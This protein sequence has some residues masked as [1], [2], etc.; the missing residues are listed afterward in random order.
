MPTTNYRKSGTDLDSLFEPIGGETKRA[1][2]SYRVN[3]TDISN[4][5]A[6][7]SSGSPYGTTS[8]RAGGT[9]IGSLFAAIGS[10][11]STGILYG[12]GRNQRAELAIVTTPYSWIVMGINNLSFLFDAP[13]AAI[14][15]DYKLFT[16]GSNI[17]GELGLN[18]VLNSS[19]PVQ[20]GFDTDWVAISAGKNFSAAI[21]SDGTLWVWGLNDFGQLGQGNLVDSLIPIQ[22]GTANDWWQISCGEAFMVGLKANRQLYAWGSNYR[23]QLGDASNM[24]KNIPTAIGTANDWEKI[25]AGG[26]HSIARKMNGTI[27]ATGYNQTGQLG[28]GGN[29]DDRNTYGQAGTYSLWNEIATGRFHSLSIRQNTDVRTWGANNTGQLGDGTLSASN[30]PRFIACPTT[31]SSTNFQKSIFEVYPNPVSNQLQ[32]NTNLP[33]F[34]FSIFSIDNKLIK[35]G[36]NDLMIDFSNFKAGIYLLE[37]Y[38]NEERIIKKIIKQ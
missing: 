2:V 5:Y 11:S 10:V 20:L 34:N 28:S 21:K 30:T 18:S 9:D 19:I 36:K 12:W 6:P 26:F 14:R 13:H 8:F 16:W 25:S 32:I 23:G 31:L 1:D 4:Y 22:V 27:W 38:H 3:G 37:I 17:Y 33:E 15:S 35:Q 7:A 29:Y 24:D